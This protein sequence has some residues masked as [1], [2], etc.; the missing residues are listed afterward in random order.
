MRFTIGTI[1]ALAAVTAAVSSCSSDAAG[2]SNGPAGSQR[3]ATFAIDSALGI[4][5]SRIEIHL[6]PGELVAREAHV[7]ADDLEEK[8]VSAVTAIDPAQG[9]ITLD[10]GG[11]TLT[12]DAGTRFRTDA[13]SNAARA[14]WEAAVQSELSAGRHP[15]IEARRNPPAAPQAPDDASFTAADLRLKTGAEDPTIELYM[16]GD[17][18]ES[19]SGSSAVL[20]VLGLVIQVND[21]TSLVD[22]NAG[23]GPGAAGSVQFGMGV[24]SVDA[25]AGTLTLANGT[26]VRVTSSTAI[27]TAGDLFTLATTANAV[28]AGQ[29]V[30]AEGRGT[31][32]SAGPPAIINAASLKIEVDD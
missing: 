32:E 21:R 6:F 28:A 30:R 3:T 10:L 20:R 27:S 19:V 12:Y 29:P 18:L 16:D 4:G 13:E 15:V 14:A 1:A 7:E 31:V 25:A 2:P 5:T 26:V 23:Q 17:N 24:T 22:D 8:I 9:T 11:L